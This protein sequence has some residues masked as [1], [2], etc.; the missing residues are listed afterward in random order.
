MVR[1]LV[2]RHS[3]DIANLKTLYQFHY[4][5][6]TDAPDIDRDLDLFRCESR[7]YARLKGHGLCEKGHIPD[8]YGVIKD[9]DPQSWGWEQHFECF[10]ED[11][12]RPNAILIEYIPN[13]RMIDLSNFS[14]ERVQKL[15]DI[16]TE[17]HSASVYHAD[18]YPRNMMV[19]ND[20]NR[21]LWIDFDRAQTFNPD[22]ITPEQQEWMEFEGLYIDEYVCE[23]VRL[24]IWSL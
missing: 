7:A 21:V 6:L 19:Q 2:L 8:F 24:E 18:H 4:Q 3:S 1:T 14:E 17:I 10:I 20:S 23:I 5:D 11:L 13:M 16:L 12:K 9:I 15:R 22:S